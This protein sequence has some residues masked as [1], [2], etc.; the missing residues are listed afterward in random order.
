VGNPNNNKYTCKQTNKNWFNKDCYEGKKEFKRVRNKYNRDKTI[1]NRNGLIRARSNYNKIKRKAY[2]KHRRQN[3]IKINNL[4]STDARKFWK[5]IKTPSHTKDVG[6]DSLTLDDLHNHFKEMFG[7]PTLNHDQVGPNYVNQNHGEINDNLLDAEINETEIRKAVLTQNNHKSPG[8]DQ[9]PAEIFK[10]SIDIL[11]PF[12]KVLY[13]RIFFNHEYPQAWGTGII[14]PI[15]KKGDVNDVKNYRGVTLINTLAKVY[16]Q[17]LLN[18]LTKWSVENEKLTKNQFGFQKGKSISDCIFILHSIISKVLSEK[19]KLYCVFI[20]YQ[21]FFDRIGHPYLW[22]KLLNENVSSHFVKA[23][24]AMYNCV[25][26]CVRYKSSL[27]PFFDA[28]ATGVKQGDPSSP[29]LAMFFINDLIN[30][31]NSNLPGLISLDIIKIF[32][33]FYADDMVLFA[34]SPESLSLMLKDV[35]LYCNTWG[36]KINVTKTKAMIFENGRSTHIN[37]KIYDQ[38]IEVV[39]SFRYLGIF[40]FKNG[41]FN[42]SQK[43]IAQHASFSLNKLFQIFNNTELPINQKVKLFDVLVGS[44]L[45][46]CSEI[47]GMHPATDIEM[48]HV[49]FLRYI[50]GVKKSTNL[51]ALYGELGRLPMLIHR[52]F[53]LIKYWKKIISLEDDSL[54]KKTYYVLRNDDYNDKTY[55]NKNWAT[56]VK[57][58]LFEHGFQDIWLYEN[59]DNY[60]VELIKKRITDTYCQSWYSN[61]NNSPRLR[62]YA[63]FKHTLTREKYLDII[64]ENKFRYALARFRV[65]AHRLAIETGRYTGTEINER[66]CLSCNMN[67][68]ESEYHF[69][70]VCPKYR[71]LRYKFLKPYFCRWPTLNKFQFLLNCNSNKTLYSLAKYIYF[72]NRIRDNE[73][74]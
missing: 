39:D 57:N 24:K 62:T 26:S 64:H 5:L 34:K 13:N 67:Q 8:I 36:L 38:P 19:E 20:D 53:N 22:Q 23:I 44:V 1:E 46:F 61:I 56:Q 30:N 41:N 68:V 45:N 4:A 25:K 52:K 18:R 48:I 12:L 74:K 2:I 29:L 21:N 10:A 9:L 72:A 49:K 50:L 63:I 17:I 28:S 7:Q 31:I 71:E 14:V 51:D 43:L 6:A 47:W 60:T 15:F 33:L 58:I 27:S 69:L 66:I 73:I 59:I 37:L 3:G 55:K 70:L 40:L 54:V 16:S 32:L 35:E 11:L 65:S 42:R